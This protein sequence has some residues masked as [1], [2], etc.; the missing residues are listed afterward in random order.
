[1]CRV[2]RNPLS[3]VIA[4]SLLLGIPLNARASTVVIGSTA[5]GITF[6]AVGGNSVNVTITPQ[7]GSTLFDAEPLTGNFTLSATA[8]SAGPG[9]GIPFQIFPAGPNTET[10][11][12]SNPDGDALT[13]IVH[14][15]FIQDDTTNPKFFGTYTI[16]SIGGDAQFLANFNLGQIGSTDFTTSALVATLGGQTLDQVVVADGIATAGI[17]SGEVVELSP[18]SL[19]A[20]LPLFVSG[21]VGLGLLG[22]RRKRKAVVAG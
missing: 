4:L 14:W 11:T 17:S 3:A 1:M 12:Y 6:T 15:N 18:V 2:L 9:Q 10:F 16:T 7:S 13:A 21:L 5:G 22:W 20:A 8:F 19:P